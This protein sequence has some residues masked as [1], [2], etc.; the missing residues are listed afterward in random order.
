M[1]KNSSLPANW[2][3]RTVPTDV[4][5]HIF[6]IFHREFTSSIAALD[7]ICTT[8]VCSRWRSI[9]N[10]AP[11]LWTKVDVEA[12]CYREFCWA[13]PNVECLALVLSRSQGL[14]LTMSLVTANRSPERS[15]LEPIKAFMRAINRAKTLSIATSFAYSVRLLHPLAL[16]ELRDGLKPEPPLFLEELVLDGGIWID[17]AIT[18]LSDAWKDAPAL[19]SV[20][21]KDG[22]CLGE[23]IY[24]A[25]S[26]YLPLHQLAVLWIELHIEDL[27]KILSS[28]PRLVTGVFHITAWNGLHQTHTQFVRLDFLRD[29][30]AHAVLE[31]DEVESEINY[32]DRN[33]PEMR[34]LEFISSPSLVKLSLC[35][36]RHMWCLA[37]FPKFID[38]SSSPRIEEFHLDATSGSQEDKIECLKRL[39]F[40][41]KLDMTIDHYVEEWREERYIGEVFWAA[42]Q[43]WDAEAEEFIVCPYLEKITVG[44]NAVSTSR[45]A[46]TAFAH[47]AKERWRRSTGSQKFEL[48]ITDAYELEEDGELS[49]LS[50][51]LYLEKYG[52]NLTIY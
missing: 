7:I 14:P 46:W 34:I 15:D 26:A 27:F 21:I 11:E 5:R 47:M 17:G 2:L 48:I 29:L 44:Y 3:I 8:H 22:P 50:P 49:N 18:L 19:K 1:L 43:E 6:G 4:W 40:L 10:G 13:G 41:R 31:E 38:I 32:A 45:V 36:W 33:E 20:S 30:T 12:R 37:S 25:K 23:S 28:T 42:L 52:F 16:M 9:I 39:P 24:D 35:F 51:L